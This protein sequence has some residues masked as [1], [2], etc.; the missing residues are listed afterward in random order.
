M[1]GGGGEGELRSWAAHECKP[2]RPLAATPNQPFDPH[3]LASAPSR[4]TGTPPPTACAQTH[5]PPCTRGWRYRL[6]CGTS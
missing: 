2:A 5:P 6:A 1:R 3:C 4:P